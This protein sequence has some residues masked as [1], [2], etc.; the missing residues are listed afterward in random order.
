MRGMHRSI[1]LL[2]SRRTITTMEKK[3]VNTMWQ[4]L[5]P[6]SSAPNSQSIKLRVSASVAMLFG[7]KV[8][9]VQIPF[10]FKNLVDSLNI[11]TANLLAQQ[12]TNNLFLLTPE[13]QFFLLSTPIALTLSYGIARSTAAGINELKN[14][15]FSTVAHSTIR[16]ISKDIFTHLHKLD[17][18]FHLDKNTGIL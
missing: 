9:G 16:I 11:D 4:H 18:S 2:N 5:W 13:A 17:L 1:R 7:S 14:A 6:P 10:I 12:S 3:I 8:I 15:I